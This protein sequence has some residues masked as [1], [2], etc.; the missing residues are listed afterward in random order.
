MILLAT[1][2]SR[3]ARNTRRCWTRSRSPAGRNQERPVL[4]PR[5]EWLVPWRRTD[6]LRGAI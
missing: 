3:A 1:Q 4:R 6:C 5:P 2:K